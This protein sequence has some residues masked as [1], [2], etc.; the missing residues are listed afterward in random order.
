M[1]VVDDYF[2]PIYVIR[3]RPGTTIIQTW[4][5]CGAF[6]KFGYSVLDKS[7]GADEALA[8]PRADPL[9][10][11]RLPGRRRQAVAPH[12]A[13]A[14]RQPLERFRVA[15][16]AS[17][18]RTSCS[19]RSGWPGRR[20]AVRDRYGIPDG[21][22]G[23]PLRA[24]VPRRQRRPTRAATDD[25]DLR[26]AA[27]RPRRRPRRARPAPPVHPRADAPIG[28]ELAGFAIDVSDHPDINE[29]LLVSDVLVTDYSSVIYEFALLGRPMVFFAPDLE[30][31]ERERGF[32]FD[33]R[34]GVPGPGL[35]DDRRRWP[36]TCAPGSSTSSVSTR[37]RAASFDVADGGHATASRTS[38]S[39]PS[40]T[41]AG[42]P[43]IALRHGP[44]EG[45]G[46]RYRGPSIPGASRP[47]RQEPTRHHDLPS[48]ARRQA[49]PPT[50]VG[51]R[52]TDGTST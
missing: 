18:A 33:Y 47:C 51:E 11:R 14:F 39:C 3:P 31:Y 38:S 34:T 16:S 46:V 19:A 26:P 43:S 1:F 15:T 42:R 22:P 30:A 35:R 27:R 7:F 50:R 52:R 13:E 29:L 36:R 49:R 37:F 12:Y 25:L 41:R 9:Q 20:D 6:K 8:E 21:Q 28:P 24:D 44:R 2:F 45:C 48:Q 10:L 17:R 5:A 40:L 32:Y 4:H 23:H